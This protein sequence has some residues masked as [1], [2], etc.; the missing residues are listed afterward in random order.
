[1]SDHV[2]GMLAR[3]ANNVPT[4]LLE[5]I[6]MY[7]LIE[8]MQSLKVFAILDKYHHITSPTRPTPPSHQNEPEYASKPQASLVAA[9]SLQ[10]LFQVPLS[11]YIEITRT[12]NLKLNATYSKAILEKEGRR[13]PAVTVTP[14]P[15]KQRSLLV[16][17]M[18]FIIVHGPDPHSG[19]RGRERAGTPPL[20]PVKKPVTEPLRPGARR[21]PVPDDLAAPDGPQDSVSDRPVTPDVCWTT[22]L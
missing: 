20:K 15:H 10:G 18:M 19:M 14:N 2:E 11:S 7:E 5:S 9:H 1:M 21:N 4:S 8:S 22:K 12:Q 16:H 3:A 13:P 6:T 17:S